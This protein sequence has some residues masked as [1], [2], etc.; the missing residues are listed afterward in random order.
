MVKQREVMKKTINLLSIVFIISAIIFVIKTKDNLPITKIV[1]TN[2]EESPLRA[3]SIKN[4]NI[5]YYYNKKNLPGKDVRQ[6]NDS[7]RNQNIQKNNEK[8]NKIP[9]NGIRRSNPPSLRNALLERKRINLSKNKEKLLA[10]KKAQSLIPEPNSL[11]QPESPLRKE[12]S[13]SVNK[14]ELSKELVNQEEDSGPYNQKNKIDRTEPGF[15]DF[16]G[17]IDEVSPFQSENEVVSDGESGLTSVENKTDKSDLGV[18]FGSLAGFVTKDT[19]K[20]S[21]DYKNDSP[22]TI[23]SGG[24]P[25]ALPKLPE[26]YKKV[27]TLNSYSV[28][29]SSLCLV[30]ENSLFC[31]GSNFFGESDPSNL[32]ED[33]VNLSKVSDFEKITKSVSSGGF[34]T[35]LILLDNTGICYGENELNKLSSDPTGF[36]IDNTG[37]IIM[38]ISSIELGKNSG[39][40]TTKLGE[41][42]CWGLNN[43]GQAGVEPTESESGGI[44]ATKI[45]TDVLFKKIKVYD[46]HAC[47]LS[48]QDKLYCW[49]SNRKGKL[50]LNNLDSTF[51]PSPVIGIGEVLDFDLGLDHTCAIKK[52]GLSGR[53]FCWGSNN[54]GQILEY[55]DSY[56]KK[57]IMISTNKFKKIASSDRAICAVDEQDAGYCWGEISFGEDGQIS[58]KMTKYPNMDSVLSI[59][60]FGF[61]FCFKSINS[62]YCIGKNNSKMFGDSLVNPILLPE[63]LDY[64]GLNH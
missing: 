57:P 20:T 47:G 56:S 38:N 35:C 34:F 60:G 24:L 16:E 14:G 48:N 55:E 25:P 59:E 8:F 5:N 17:S 33:T 42:Y 32:D 54:F 39:C 21:T 41:G 40:L 28:G 1:N 45:I 63:K 6:I 51:A 15:P 7:Y 2:K 58:K 62:L 49:G 11:N 46:D 36:I 9:N 50:G 10:D 31:R 29:D 18:F 12:E 27:L 19:D 64:S 3:N 53:L 61:G 37:E 13:E 26:T 52:E 22:K 44:M 30:V 4:R 23:S 43:D